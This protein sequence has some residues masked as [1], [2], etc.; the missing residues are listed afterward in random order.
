MDNRDMVADLDTQLKEEAKMVQ[1]SIPLLRKEVQNEGGKKDLSKRFSYATMLVK[2]GNTEEN[3]EGLAILR[4]LIDCDWNTI[5]CL[6]LLALGC[7]RMEQY[8]E[9]RNYCENLLRVDPDNL[10]GQRLHRA[11]VAKI[12]ARDRAA[13]GVA[14]G[15]FALAGVAGLIAGLL[16][17]GAKRR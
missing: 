2:S 3:K 17:S 6:Y 4:D 8:I 10:H 7:Y 9:G 5:D 1:D 13:I 15:G 16:F 12:E 11:L 14:V